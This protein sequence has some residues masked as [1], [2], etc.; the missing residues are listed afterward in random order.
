MTTT[1]TPRPRSSGNLDDRG[2]AS[3]GDRDD[4]GAAAVDHAI[5]RLPILILYP[6]ARCDCR[7]GMCDIWRGPGH[8]L[9]DPTVVAA[10]VEGWRDLG[11]RRVVLSGGEP[12]LHPRL[13]DIAAPIAAAGIGI[14][15][16]TAGLQLERHA[17]D[18]ARHV[19]DVVVSLD[20]PPGVHDTIRGVPGAFRR[21]A[22]GVAAVRARAPRPA[23][24][25]RCTV[26]Q[27]NF[28]HLRRIVDTALGIGVDAVSFL[29][30][31]ATSDAFNR[32][33]GWPT[34]RRDAVALTTADLPALRAELDALFAAH[35]PDFAGGFIVE[36]PAKLDRCLFDHFAALAG[37]GDFPP[38]TCNAPWVSAV[39]TADGAVQ[40]CF[41][42]PP[43]GRWG[44][45]PLS[46][47][48]NAAPALDFRRGLDVAANPVCRQCVCRLNLA[49]PVL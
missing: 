11:V 9:L 38:A 8:A 30:V 25:A 16:L 40:P 27:A 49:T 20:G 5:T 47:V 29:A 28:R 31:D 18:V 4:G 17:A 19:D 14:T 35:G 23:V 1:L 39:V 3:E 37:H 22:A 24:T 45:A 46:D 32:P 43:V 41:F 12:L 36:S 34:G 21:L 42:H 48:L 33:G 10:S 44:G 6:F 13:W 2:G 26:Q 7:C 15:L